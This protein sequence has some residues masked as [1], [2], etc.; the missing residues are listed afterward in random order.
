MQYECVSVPSR[1]PPSTISFSSS[2]RVNDDTLFRTFTRRCPRRR[3]SITL[4]GGAFDRRV[5][6]LRKRFLGAML[7]ARLGNSKKR[8][9][10]TSRQLQAV[11][12][13]HRTRDF[14]MVMVCDGLVICFT[15]RIHH[16]NA[17]PYTPSLLHSYTNSHSTVSG[18]SLTHARSYSAVPPR[19]G[20]L[21]T[22]VLAL[23][24]A[25]RTCAWTA[26]PLLCCTWL[27]VG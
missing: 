5:A 9:D 1:T 24:A 10:K 27:I 22:S 16:V 25:P 8:Q 20:F 3:K 21:D 26:A 2:C 11:G 19:H 17:M 7:H 23:L 18:D 4:Q 13:G 12:G 6:P 15:L 14:V